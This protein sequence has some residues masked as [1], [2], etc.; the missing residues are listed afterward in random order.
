MC[1]KNFVFSWLRA[2]LVQLINSSSF[3]DKIIIAHTYLAAQINNNCDPLS[4]PDQ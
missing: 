1:N 3:S 4:V 2:N